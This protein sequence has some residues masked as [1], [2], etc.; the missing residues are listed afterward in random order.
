MTEL[1]DSGGFSTIIRALK[2]KKLSLTAERY[3]EGR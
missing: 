2:D 3:E 1:T